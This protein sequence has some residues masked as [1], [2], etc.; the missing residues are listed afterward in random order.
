MKGHQS[1][2]QSSD[3]LDTEASALVASLGSVWRHSILKVTQGMQVSKENMHSWL[4][5]V[6]RKRH[7]PSVI[8]SEVLEYTGL[9]KNIYNF[10]TSLRA[11]S[12]WTV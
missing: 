6:L 10:Q 11:T 1:L 8:Y 3:Y 12:S 4:L 9:N 5:L 2:W 7:F